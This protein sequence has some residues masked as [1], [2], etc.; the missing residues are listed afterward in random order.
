[1]RAILIC[2]AMLLFGSTLVLAHEGAANPANQATRYWLSIYTGKW[3]QAFGLFHDK[4]ACEE[5]GKLYP[6]WV[7][8]TCVPLAPPQAVKR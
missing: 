1:M 8:R 2:T 5:A 4:A 6:R 3:A 7:Y